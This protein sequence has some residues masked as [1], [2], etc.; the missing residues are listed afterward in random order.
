[1]R[2]DENARSELSQHCDGLRPDDKVACLMSFDVASSDT[3]RLGSYAVKRQWIFGVGFF[4]WRDVLERLWDLKR[5]G[6]GG[7]DAQHSYRRRKS[8][9]RHNAARQ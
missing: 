7:D 1:M 9:L 8:T 4:G 5:R 6:D 2:D 3:K